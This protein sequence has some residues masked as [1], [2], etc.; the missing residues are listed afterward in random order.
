MDSSKIDAS[1]RAQFLASSSPL[2]GQWLLA[3]PITSCGLRL[4]DEAIRVAVA[5]RLGLNL[6][7]PHQCRCG[8]MVDARG[9]HALVCKHAPSRTIRHQQLNDLI[10][11]AIASAGIPVTKEPTGLTRCDGRR[12]DGMTLIPWREGKLLLWDVTVVNPLAES[13]ITTASRTAG[14]VAEQVA[15]RKCNKYAD[16]SSAYSFLPLAFEALGPADIAAR[17]FL[18]DLGSKISSVTADPRETAFLYQRISVTIQRFNCS[19][20]HECFEKNP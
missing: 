12:P 6:G 4:E 17:E 20:Y 16:L 18:Q 19:L 1:Q 10:T 13:Y 9:V 14:G 15:E 11:R 5:L 2:S 3:L 7:A 8:T